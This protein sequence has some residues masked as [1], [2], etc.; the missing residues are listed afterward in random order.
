[1]SKFERCS[2]S[3]IISQASSLSRSKF[4]PATTSFV[5]EVVETTKKTLF[6]LKE[7]YPPFAKATMAETL[8]KTFKAAV[9]GSKGQDLVLQ[10][11][12]L[13][14]PGPGHVL[15][16]VVACGV[17]HSDRFLQQGNFGDGL[18]PR[19]PGHEMVGDVVAVG[20]GV[21]RF[22]VGERVGGAWHGGKHPPL[23]ITVSLVLL[24]SLQL[25]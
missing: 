1:M 11:V 17:C 24:V 13:H 6:Y 10:D 25:K 8:P 3:I 21:T 5:R 22:K 20:G 19:V 9:I 18:F 14:A 2:S 4:K 15:I 16:K 23:L 12:D 7:A